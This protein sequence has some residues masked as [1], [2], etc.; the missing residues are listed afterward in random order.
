MSARFDTPTPIDPIDS[1]K[2]NLS[3]PKSSRILR[4]SDF[5]KV[6]DGGFRFSTQY[7]AA[8]CLRRAEPGG[9]RIGFTVPRALGKAVTRNRLRRRVREAVRLQFQQL[10]TQWDIVINP[11]RSALTAP[12]E[13][14]SREV[15]RLFSRCKA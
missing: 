2:R 10:E 5:R 6:Y 12:F 8:F 3:L 4:S 13:A 14:L 9:S 1:A 15:S 7:F 11:R